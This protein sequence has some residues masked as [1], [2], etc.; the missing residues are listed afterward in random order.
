VT[1]EAVVLGPADVPA[2]AAG[3]GLF[4]A[5]APVPSIA[6]ATAA[7]ARHRPVR[8]AALPGDALVVA[9]TTLGS[10][11][12]LPDDAA[13]RAVVRVA[14]Q[15]ARRRIEAV[16]PLGAR[17]VLAAVHAAA[18]LGLPCA[19]TTAAG[20]GADRLDLTPLALD[21]VAADPVVAS[22]DGLEVVAVRRA[23][24][25]AAHR[26]A[27]TVAGDMDGA[28]VTAYPADAERYATA[29][30]AV[31]RCLL[32]GRALLRGELP[33]PPLFTGTVADVAG[34][35]RGTATL[36]GGDRL[37]RL[38]YD[39]TY[40][41]GTE[42]GVV[43]A[44]TPDLV[45]VLDANRGTPVPA[46]RLAVGERVHVFVVPAAPRWLLQDGLSAAGP[47]RFG[48]DVNHVRTTDTTWTTHGVMLEIGS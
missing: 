24:A 12:A 42:D 38:D 26:I 46:D 43:R 15:Q 35:G 22:R 18:V 36:T 7:L 37:L 8:L 27:A 30:G 28:V 25:A 19:D 45:C 3:A 23:G 39:G 21:G 32:T 4:A 13:W 2:L 17:D 34:T 9:V 29:G 14:G 16:L 48:Y 31:G 20:R 6:R 44:A 41:V 40:L 10:A 33:A 11:R 47:R 5:G 1:G